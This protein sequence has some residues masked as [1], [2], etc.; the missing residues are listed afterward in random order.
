MT[1]LPNAFALILLM[2][3]A[4]TALGAAAERPADEAAVETRS[5]VAETV[6]DLERA[7]DTAVEAAVETAVE[8]EVETRAEG[9]AG[10]ERER[11]IEIK[12]HLEP[13]DEPFDLIGLVAVVLIFGM[14]ILIVAIVGYNNRRRYEQVHQ[15]LARL[16]E[17]DAPLPP[18]LLDALDQGKTPRSRLHAGAVN[19]AAGIGLGLFLWAVKNWEV[20]TLG[21]VPLLIGLAQLAIWRLE[22]PRVETR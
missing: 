13:G 15:T 6:E 12:A 18:A 22:A 8:T 5:V 3:T 14:P 21:L 16:I 1:I 4:E 7:I 9:Q 20:A 2:L 10:P 19:C 17:R 11:Q